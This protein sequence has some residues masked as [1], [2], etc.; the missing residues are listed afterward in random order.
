MIFVLR[1]VAIGK[2]VIVVSHPKIEGICS[3]NV[4]NL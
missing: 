1:S 2:S 3:N 4:R